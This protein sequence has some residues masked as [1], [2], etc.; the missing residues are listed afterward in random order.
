[1][2]LDSQWV[3]KEI[4]RS[5]EKYLRTNEN[6]NK[7]YQSLWDEAKVVLWGKFTAI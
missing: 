6:R 2:L 7:M 5:I 3:T 1:M 4:N